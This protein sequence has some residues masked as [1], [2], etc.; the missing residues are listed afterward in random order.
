MK[1]ILRVSW[2]SSFY[3]P[4]LS[5]NQINLRNRIFDTTSAPFW[6]VV[7]GSIV[8]ISLI[9]VSSY[10][11][12]ENLHWGDISRRV[13]GSHWNFIYW[14]STLLCIFMFCIS[15]WHELKC[16]Q[17]STRTFLYLTIFS[18]NDFLY[19]LPIMNTLKLKYL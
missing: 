7:S 5:I 1:V 13:L 17:K 2:G 3:L 14:V 9:A 11:F 6:Y 10:N 8:I 18:L 16:D 15:S 12:S 19:K 4:N